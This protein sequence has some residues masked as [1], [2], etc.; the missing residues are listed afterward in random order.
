MRAKR[1]FSHSGTFLE[2]TVITIIPK[3]KSLY[4]HSSIYV[5]NVGTHKK[6]RKQKP[7]KLRLLS[8]TKGEE[9]KIEL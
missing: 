7:G 2:L 5:V 8:S 3:A 6:T 1:N 9:N 4:R